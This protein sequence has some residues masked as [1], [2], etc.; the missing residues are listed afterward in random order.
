MRTRRHSKKHT[1][2]RCVHATCV[3]FLAAS[4]LFGCK[5]DPPMRQTDATE[6]SLAPQPPTAAE[7]RDAQP[8]VTVDDVV[9]RTRGDIQ[10]RIEELTSRYIETPGTAPPTPAWRDARRRALVSETVD[11]Y[12]I[13][14]Y[15]AL[16]AIPIPSQ[17]ETRAHLAELHPHIFGEEE[18]FVRY[19]AARHLSAQD[20]ITREQRELALAHHF[21]ANG[22][23]HISEE[24][25]EAYYQTQRERL[26]ARERVLVSTITFPLAADAPAHIAEA[27]LQSL[28][29]L[30]ASILDEALSFDE[31]VTAHSQGVPGATSGDLGWV[32]RGEERA[33]VAAGVERTIFRLSPGEVSEPLRTLSG[34]Q[35]FYVRDKRRAGVR[36]LDEVEESMKRPLRR[37]RIREL[38][39]E[40]MD[41]RRLAHAIIVYDDVIGYELVEAP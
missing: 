3:A 30:R 17:E 26:R 33:W 28:N 23:L 32:Q 13:A 31:A 21:E 12:V 14:N 10:R 9:I 16:N 20:F 8:A 6:A 15:L 40:L 37:R 7:R 24:E 2:A 38:R 27:Q 36:T 18:L 34:L 22:Q 35:L 29:T 39:Q 11:D 19:L 5:S 41:Q 25:L 4:V 1:R